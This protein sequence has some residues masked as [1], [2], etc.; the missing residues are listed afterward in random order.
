MN[1]LLGVQMYVKVNNLVSSRHS[2]KKYND[3]HNIS[4]F[5]AVEQV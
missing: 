2:F 5:F 4:G 3:E 1:T